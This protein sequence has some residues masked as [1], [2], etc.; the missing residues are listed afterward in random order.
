MQN[1]CL[2]QPIESLVN[3]YGITDLFLLRN[4]RQLILTG[5]SPDQPE[6]H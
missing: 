3:L 5:L 4:P 1:V 2:K 6:P